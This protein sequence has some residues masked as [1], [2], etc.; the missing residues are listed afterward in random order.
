[1]LEEALCAFGGE[2]DMGV[3]RIDP[4]LADLVAVD[5][6]CLAKHRQEPFG[7]GVLLAA[8]IDGDPDGA[9]DGSALAL[10][11]GFAWLARFAV[12][13]V[14][15]FAGR[16][17]RAVLPFPLAAIL[18]G[19]AGRAVVYLAQVFGR[20]PASARLADEGGG[21][22]LG[23]MLRH[24]TGN[25]VR[26][27]FHHRIG[28][29]RIGQQAGIIAR[30]DLISRWRAAPAGFDFCVL[31]EALD[32][33]AGLWR[34]D[35]CTDALAASA[36]CAARAVEQGGRIARQVRMDHKVKFRKVKTAGGDICCDADAGPAGAQ[37]GEGVGTLFLA[38][39][40]R[41]GHNAEAAIAETRDEVVHR[42]AGGAEDYGA[43][44]IRMAHDVDDGVFLVAW[45]D[46]Q[47]FIGDVGMRGGVAGRGDAQGIFLIAAGER[48]NALG[49]GSR[50]HQG[51][52]VCR[53]IFEDVL[54]LFA[55]AHVEHLVS[56]IEHDG[57][58]FGGV[59][60]ATID[61]V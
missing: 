12:G 8:D 44:G 54:K 13:P 5:A 53:R 47:R 59:E 52:A 49:H 30:G 27:L 45:C 26:F 41:Q 17:L 19:L 46:H 6:A 37:G 2:L 29:G 11:A 34:N 61:M 28:E 50:E 18:A 22:L 38:E 4:D 36:A 33:A 25:K 24:Q 16:A 35:Q 56:L 31:K 23:R 15:A 14:P 1:M 20:R 58:N 32:A 57:A 55:E 3:A 51:T 40:S 21:D 43:F 7:I 42:N 10:G 9:V 48:G 60:R 39:L